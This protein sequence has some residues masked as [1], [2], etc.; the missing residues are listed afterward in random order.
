M[1]I[2]AVGVFYNKGKVL[3]EK[4]SDTEDN[5]AGLWAFP[6]GHQE[7]NEAIEKTL[8]REINEELGIKLKK[9]QKI[10]IFNDIDP[11]SGKKYKHVA[12]ICIDWQGRPKQSP[13]SM[14]LKWFKI[15]DISKK[16]SSKVDLEILEK[17]LGMIKTKKI[18]LE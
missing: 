15:K 8:T 4:R 1:D 9:Y 18:K 14:A 3:M 7:K 11:T 5:Y 16:Y 6:G 12:F 17:T 13:F 2:V 10:G